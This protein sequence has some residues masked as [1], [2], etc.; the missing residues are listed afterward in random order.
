M[1]RL[2]HTRRTARRRAFTIIEL[3]VVTVVVL[4]LMS[5]LV[6]ASSIATDTVRAAKA[7]GNH[8]SQERAIVALIRRDLMRDHFLEEDGKPNQGRKLSDQR[9]DRLFLNAT[10]NRLDGYKPPRAGYFFASSRPAPLTE[11]TWAATNDATWNFPENS[12]AEGFRSSRS[13]NHVLQFTIVVPGGAPEDRLV[14][15]VPASNGQS[16]T[17]TC[18]EVAYFLVPNISTS[19]GVARYKLIRRWRIAART[20]DDAP[21]Y[22]ALLNAPP[23]PGPD[24]NDPP[25]V[26]AVIG[27]PAPNFQ[28]LTMSDLALG[29]RVPRA[30]ISPAT[31]FRVGEDV[32]HDSV[33]S[34]EVKFTGSVGPTVGT[35]LSWAAPGATDT[36]T[37]WPRPFSGS[38]PNTDYPYDNLPYDGNYDTFNQ[39]INNTAQDW[40]QPTNLATSA[41]PTRTLKRIRITGAMI[42]LR[43]WSPATKTTR[44][45]TMMVDL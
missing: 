2:T 7:Q 30:Q 17:G 35:D 18:G 41:F 31:G 26:M 16:I 29:N 38:P 22:S 10:T 14:V 25:E 37:T 24:K 39:L 42:R 4:I 19:G 1:I 3:M 20:G 15:N 8:M 11:P 12:D 9:T 45:T 32:L 6:A 23:L 13:A 21:A 33:T 34:F 27:G 28:M 40:N 44:Q 5:I 43:C 36:S